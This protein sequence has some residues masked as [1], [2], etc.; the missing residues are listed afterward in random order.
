M[1]ITTKTIPTA[2]K[3]KNKFGWLRTFWTF[4]QLQDFHKSSRM[5]LVIETTKGVFT[6]DLYVDQKPKS[7]LINCLIIAP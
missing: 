1:K 3:N 5:S 6:C 7:K 4:F 2:K